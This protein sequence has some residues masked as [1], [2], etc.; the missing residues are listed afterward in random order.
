M[1]TRTKTQAPKH[2]KHHVV[3]RSSRRGAPIQAIAVHSTESQD[4]KGTTDDLRSVRSW[5]NNPASDA[6]SHIGI[7]GQG[8]T[9]LWVPSTEK[10]WTILQLNDRTLNIEFIGRSAQ[11]S[12]DWEDE[13]IKQGARWVA[14]WAIRFDLPIQK[15][16]VRNVNGYPVIS[17]KGVIRHSDLTHAG[18]GDHEDPGA[19]FPMRKLLDQAQWYRRNGW[20]TQ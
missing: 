19:N 11:T 8:N 14:Y 9:E 10:A 7:D 2:E 17:K 6:S 1:A 12:K 4:L 16:V 3:N 20:T 13:Q 5:F 15:G 18:F